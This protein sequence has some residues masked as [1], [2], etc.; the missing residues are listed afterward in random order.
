MKFVVRFDLASEDTIK[1]CVNQELPS[2]FSGVFAKVS[3][4]DMRAVF[5]MPNASNKS[6]HEL[7]RTKER[8]SD[9]LNEAANTLFR[10]CRDTLVNTVATIEIGRGELATAK[11]RFSRGESDSDASFGQQ[12]KTNA[13]KFDLERDIVD[14]FVRSLGHTQFSLTDPNACQKAD[15]G[16]DVLITLHG[17]HYGIQ[18]TVYHADE[19][20]NS[21]QKGSNVWRQEAPH[22]VIRFMPYAK[23]NALA[24]RSICESLW[25]LFSKDLVV[26][27]CGVAAFRER[28]DWIEFDGR[29]FHFSRYWNRAA[30]PEPKNSL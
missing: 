13:P 11:G 16:A 7:A 23:L 30:P 25:S 8:I 18:V 2:E 4:E 1:L 9:A 17:W 14:R 15:T 29:S 26:P 27:K 20:M 12:S 22:E 10:A 21:G 3:C 28:L 24:K 5:E 19:G 6:C